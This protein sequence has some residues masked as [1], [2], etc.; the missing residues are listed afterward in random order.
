MSEPD[1]ATSPSIGF[2]NFVL[3][4]TDGRIVMVL[5][6]KSVGCW[7]TPED[8][9]FMSVHMEICLASHAPNNQQTT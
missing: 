5:L 1:A 6:Y 9:T 8:K 2:V 4:D 7:A 3:E